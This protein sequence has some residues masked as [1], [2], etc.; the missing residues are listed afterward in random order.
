MNERNNGR[1]KRSKET[2]GGQK[3]T[4]DKNER[5]EQWVDQKKQNKQWESKE[6]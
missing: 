4:E 5:K 2:M 1:I 3:G 6:E